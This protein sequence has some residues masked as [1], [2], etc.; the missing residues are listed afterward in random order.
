MKGEVRIQHPDPDLSG[1]VTFHMPTLYERVAIGRRVA[2][3]CAPARWEDLPPDERALAK[4]IATL[5]YVIDTA[6]RGFYDTDRS[7][8]PVLAPGRLMSRD[9]ELLWQIWAAYV[10]LEERFRAGAGAAGGAADEAGGEPGGQGSPGSG[11]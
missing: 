1:T 11:A 8:K 3:L 9:E 2:Q 7:G 6:P 4:V 5:E 10:D